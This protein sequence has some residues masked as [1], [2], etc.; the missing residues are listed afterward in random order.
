MRFLSSILWLAIA[1]IAIVFA[2]RNWTPI[3]VNLWDNLVV[4]TYL[5][6]VVI[7]SFLIGFLPYFML[8]R[9][10][11]W[12]LN[13][14]LGNAQRELAATRATV[15]DSNAPQ[16]SPNGATIGVPT[17]VPPGVS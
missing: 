7:L 13:R 5:P 12:S 8:H 2:A 1:V 6:V 17:A 10:T 9:A 11:R 16:S 3:T 14:K 4:D 15:L